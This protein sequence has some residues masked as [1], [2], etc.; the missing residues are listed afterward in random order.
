MVFHLLQM[1]VETMLKDWLS[2]KGDLKDHNEIKNGGD[3]IKAAQG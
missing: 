1:K 3:A 2:T